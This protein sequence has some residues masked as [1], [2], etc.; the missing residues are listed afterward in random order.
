M[1]KHRLLGDENPTSLIVDSLSLVSQLARISREFYEAI[2]NAN[3]Y[4]EIKALIIH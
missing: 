3:V 1:N 4:N 2:H